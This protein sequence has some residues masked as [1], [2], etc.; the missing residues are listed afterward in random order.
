MSAVAGITVTLPVL[1][2]AWMFGLRGGF[3][4]GLLTFPLNLI[5]VTAFASQSATDWMLNG[6]IPGNLAEILVGSVVGRLRNVDHRLSEAVRKQK[7]TEEEL[8]VA[9]EVSRIITSTLDIEGVYEQ[10]ANEGKKLV[11][12]DLMN[13]S[14]IDS[15]SNKTVIQFIAGDQTGDIYAGFEMPISG[16]RMEHLRATGQ[17]MILSDADFSKDVSLE[18]DLLNAGFKSAILVPLFAGGKIFGNLGLSCRRAMA[19]SDRE[20]QILERMASQIAPAMENARLHQQTLAESRLATSSLA[21]LR[22]VLE[23]VDAAILLCGLAHD[24]LW[25]NQK[26]ADLIGINYAATDAF[27][28]GGEMSINALRDWGNNCLANPTDFFEAKDRL[29]ADLEFSGSIVEFDII[30]P[31]PRTLR[32]CAAMMATSAGCGSTATLQNGS[33][34]KKRFGRWPD[35]HRKA[36]TRFSA[37]PATPRFFTATRRVCPF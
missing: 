25:F 31:V 30:R 6:G 35:F 27:T 28:A 33:R 22:A 32:E 2:A 9:D 18:I 20:K 23:G 5:L 16:S 3:A 15:G 10:F 12:W 19:F 4:A 37:L 7:E 21:Q 34:P 8:A 1:M 11:D 26:F 17:T 24:I 36:Q 13:V 14:L 29:H